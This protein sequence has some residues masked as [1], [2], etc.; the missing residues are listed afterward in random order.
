M[1]GCTVLGRAG[2]QKDRCT[3]LNGLPEIAVLVRNEVSIL[4]HLSKALV[5]LMILLVA[6]TGAL[7]YGISSG[8]D[9]C[10]PMIASLWGVALGGITDHL[11]LEPKIQ[12][13]SRVHQ[14]AVPL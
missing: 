14:E 13:G 4:V 1:K 11:G 2:P 7:A 3:E 6:V 12:G 10:G 5:M 9:D 8:C